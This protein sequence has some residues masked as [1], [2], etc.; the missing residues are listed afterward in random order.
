VTFS[1]ASV[2]NVSVSCVELH[3]SIAIDNNTSWLYQID[4]IC[5]LARFD[6]KRFR[7]CNV[8]VLGAVVANGAAMAEWLR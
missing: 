1:F 5:L 2:R 7:F 4:W 3:L 6:M 8:L